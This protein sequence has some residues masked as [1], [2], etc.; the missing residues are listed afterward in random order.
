MPLEFTPYT[1]PYVLALV[2]SV[3]AVLVAYPN[4]ASAGGRW[5][6]LMAV[7]IVV[8][9]AAETIDF[10]STQL[11]WHIRAAQLSY[12]GAT[13]APVLYFLFAVEY[14]GRWR[15]VP[16]GAAAALMAVPAITTA[17][18][19]TNRFHS[20]VWTSFTP[21]RQEPTVILY[22]HGVAYWV[23]TIYSLV[24]GATAIALI[25]DTAVR[26]SGIFRTR[27][28]IIMAAA[29]APWLMQL[30]YSLSP[31]SVIGL[32]PS[33]ALSVTCV[34]MVMAI[35]RFRLLELTPIPREVLVEEML[36]GLVVLDPAM[37]VME[38]N[39]AAVKL[40]GLPKAPAAGAPV[41]ELFVAWGDAA[42]AA[43]S[44]FES[45]S[46]AVI[47]VPNDRFVAVTKSSVG[48]SLS[49]GVREL[50]T[51][52]D[53]TA[54]VHAE[55]AL[56]DAN[57]ALLERV[58]EIEALQAQLV[59]QA[60]R[61][62]LTGLNNRRFLDDQLP[63]ELARAA[64]GGYPLSVVMFDVDDFKQINDGGGHAAG[65]AVLIEIAVMLSA[66]TRGGDI[67]CRYGG[68][69]FVVVMPNADADSAVK[70]AAAWQW[71]LRGTSQVGLAGPLTISVGVAAFPV[72][73]ES[74]AAL[75]VAADLAV[76]AS[77]L[78]GRDR[79][80]LAGGEARPRLAG[81]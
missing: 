19:F 15:S 14:S 25:A 22:G 71:R 61:D 50:V 48:A 54:Q 26:N 63:G 46:P 3:V 58:A 30:L 67:I 17:L 59:E 79:V 24:L 13:T 76:Y 9:C 80:C 70:R 37:R 5:L 62:S 51:L 78:A 27:S 18:A 4:R 23:I 73:G 77:K 6:F 33:L 16:K 45:G 74:A 52:R 68:D 29:I 55:Q 44:A 12:I 28:M 2:L 81:V 38:L 36:N 7:A 53:V 39:P 47:E 21:Y 40:L 56:H 64:R 69:E 41:T 66:D 42:P 8:W 72:H 32:D 31:R 60:T 49:A 10:A 34:L 43:L 1:A 11:V 57:D 20:L 65:D 75:M 35:A